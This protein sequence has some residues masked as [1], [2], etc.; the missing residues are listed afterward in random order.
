VGLLPERLLRVL[1]RNAGLKKALICGK[2]EMEFEMVTGTGKSPGEGE[3]F[4]DRIQKRPQ[5]VSDCV[6][7]SYLLLRRLPTG[8]RWVEFFGGVGIQTTL[9][10]N[11]LVPVSH[12]VIERDELCYRHLQRQFPNVEIRHQDALEVLDSPP[13]ADIYILDW[14]AWTIHH[15]DR[16]E[17]HWKGLIEADPLGIIWW[18][19]S[20]AFFHVNKN[21]YAQELHSEVRRPEDYAR[22]FRHFL[23]DK[24]PAYALSTAVYCKFSTYYLLQRGSHPLEEF[25]TG[26]AEGFR[27]IS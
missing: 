19:T 16:W 3:S 7:G 20:K 2:W 9:I 1:E 13:A 5:T 12:L 15:W 26:G 21:L 4:M 11:L 24:F 22:G 18:D 6:W 27:W 23:A 10:Q 17:R 25:Y 14:N 8:L